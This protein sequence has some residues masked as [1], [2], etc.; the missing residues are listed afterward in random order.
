MAGGALFYTFKYERLDPACQEIRLLRLQPGTLDDQPRCDIE[1]VSLQSKPDFVALSYVWGNEKNRKDILLRDDPS[2]VTAN[3]ELALRYMQCVKGLSHIWIDALCI[4]Q[5]DHEEKALQVGFMADIYSNARTTYMWLGAPVYFSNVAM[6]SIRTIKTIPRKSWGNARLFAV[7]QLLARPYWTRVWVVQEAFY[8]RRAIV[9][10][11]HDEVDFNSFYDLVDFMDFHNSRPRTDRCPENPDQNLI[12]LYKFPFRLLFKLCTRDRPK[13]T[14]IQIDMF[15]WLNYSDSFSSTLPRDRVFAFLNLAFVMDKKHIKPDYSIT[16][17]DRRIFSEVTAYIVRSRSPT[18][19]LLPLQLRQVGKMLDLPSW[20]PDWTIPP[21]HDQ[22]I[23]GPKAPR[24]CAGQDDS[25][26]KKLCPDLDPLGSDILN[27]PV[28]FRFSEDLE[29][30]I[31]RGAV[32]EKIAYAVSVADGDQLARKHNFRD[33]ARSVIQREVLDACRD[34]EARAFGNHCNAYGSTAGLSDAIWRTMMSNKCQDG[35]SPPSADYG[36]CYEEWKDAVT[37]RDLAINNP[38]LIEFDTHVTTLCELRGFCLTEKG[39]V[40]LVPSTTRE[41]DIVCIFQDG[42]VPVI[43]RAEKDY[44]VWIGE[45]YIHGI[46]FGEAL[47]AAEAIDVV[48]FQVK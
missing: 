33:K 18:Q 17:S 8:S 3:L 39:H 2:N 1:V 31:I 36:V 24:H 21:H 48:V 19:Y 5:A 23:T 26:W 29:T 22:I 45:A 15:R 13:E 42:R 38:K 41:G 30:F 4:N 25:M 44:H 20:V 6:D 34:W 27:R 37:R 28:Q 40:G 10:C 47:R 11:G 35:T 7:A 16:K 32:V 46:M 12:R 9:K 43:L 14:P